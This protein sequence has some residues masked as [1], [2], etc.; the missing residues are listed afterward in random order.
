MKISIDPFKNCVTNRH[1]YCAIT[2]LLAKR[3]ASTCKRYLRWKPMASVR[4]I[5]V[6]QQSTSESE[7]VV[8]LS[9]FTVTKLKLLCKENATKTSW[10][11]ADIIGRLVTTWKAA[12]DVSPET[13]GTSAATTIDMPAF[14][15]I[16]SWTKDLSPLTHFIFMQLSHYLVSSKEKTFDKSRWRR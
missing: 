16:R 2:E 7:L 13:C 11:K 6:L 8:L 1:R 12:C 15:E 14:N 3:L 5:F 4:S 9:A 10:N